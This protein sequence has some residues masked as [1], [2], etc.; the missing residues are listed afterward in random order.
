M[1]EIGYDFN[2]KD[3]N[4]IKKYKN[5][6]LDIFKNELNDNS[7]YKILLNKN[8]IYNLL[9]NNNIKYKLI[10]SRKNKN[11]MIGD[12]IG[13]LLSMALIRLNQPYQK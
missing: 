4:K 12:G 1:I 6:T 11:I 13:N 10:Y 7:K 8:K 2:I 5:P 3:I 9:K